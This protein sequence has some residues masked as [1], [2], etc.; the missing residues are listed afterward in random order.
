MGLAA[1]DDLLEEVAL[2]GG[3]REVTEVACAAAEITEDAARVVGMIRKHFFEYAHGIEEHLER[4]GELIGIGL[5][6]VDAA[7]GGFAEDA[8]AIGFRQIDCFDGQIVFE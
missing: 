4:G 3:V 5:W 7:G 1:L 2:D 6:G 8:D